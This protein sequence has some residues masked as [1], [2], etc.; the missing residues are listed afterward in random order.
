MSKNIKLKEIEQLDNYKYTIKSN[1]NEN[2]PLYLAIHK[3]DLNL[4]DDNL[5]SID[6]IYKQ[7]NEFKNVYSIISGDYV[8]FDFNY[9][10]DNLVEFFI[11]KNK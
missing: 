8:I 3:D 7:D 11:V 9:Y 4:E 5:Y 6:A 10:K 2:N 1:L